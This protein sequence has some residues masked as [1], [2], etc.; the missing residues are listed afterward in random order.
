VS[1]PHPHCETDHHRCKCYITGRVQGVGFRYTAQNVALQY[2]IGGYVKNLRD[3]RVELVME[4]CDAEM[5]HFMDALQQRM[6]GY[7]CKI[8]RLVEP[9]TG[10]F[11]HFNIR[12]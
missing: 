6:N 2:D 9:A 5:N 7:I 3:G 11:N 10:E 12:H 8:D 4:G 1:T